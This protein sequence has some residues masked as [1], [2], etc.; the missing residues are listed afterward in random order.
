M[1]I[2][3]NFDILKIFVSFIL[4]ILA[5]F[6]KDNNVL[7]FIL[8]LT[9]YFIVSFKV[10]IE[11]FQKV[12]K[13]NFFDESNL[14]IIATISAFIIGEYPEAVMVMLLFEFGEYLSDLAVENSKRSIVKL[15]DLRS[16]YVNLKK[17]DTFKKTDINE[18]KAGD[19]FIVKPGEKF[20]LDGVIIQGKTEA[21]S[22]SLTGESVPRKLVVGSEVLSG[23]VNGSGLVTVRAV[24]EASSSMASKIINLLESADEKKT[25]TEKFITRFSKIYTPI[26][27]ILAVLI[28]LFGYLFEVK[29]YF[30]NALVFL[31]TA[32]PC[33]LVISVPLSFFCGVGRASKEGILIKGSNVFDSLTRLKTVIF[34]KTGTLT[35]G[36]FLVREIFSNKVSSLELL[37]LV[38]YGEYYSNHPLAKSILAFYDKEIDETKIKNFK[39]ISGEGVLV[40]VDSKKLVIGNEKLMERE[41]VLFTNTTVFGK[42]VYVACDGEYLGYLVVGDKIKNSAYNLV[43]E[44]RKVN[45]D[46]VVMLSGDSEDIC[47]KVASKL[48]ITEYYSELLPTDKVQKLKD[49][50]KNSIVAF[51]GDGVNDALVLKEASIGISMGGVGSDAAIEASDIVIMHDDLEKIVTSIKIAHL[52]QKIVK[53]NITFALIFKFLM[54]ILAVF[55]LAKIWMA[56]VADVGVTLFAILNAL[57]IMKKKML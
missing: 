47:Q 38:A 49:I 37:K 25:V 26:I 21:D 42:I 18:A 28:V 5:L 31:V 23:F 22:S 48:D 33:A 14:M 51:A 17:G 39:E 55:G 13:G 40:T 46:K 19:I 9:S 8:L 35:E 34:D 12:L 16:D 30:Y 41:G 56:V 50:K 43:H 57:R 54:L 3:V 24:S 10:F 15:M 53:F 6:F 32:C 4:F 36:K 20:P 45:V 52:T 44:L 11:A 7:Y 2:K 29:D 27:L 1:K